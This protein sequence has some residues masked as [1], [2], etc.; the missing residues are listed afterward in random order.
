[1]L[2]FDLI[3]SQILKQLPQKRI[4]VLTYLFNAAVRLKHVPASW[5]VAEVSQ[6]KHLMK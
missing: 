6:E 1:M 5:K 3:T 4:L 2:G